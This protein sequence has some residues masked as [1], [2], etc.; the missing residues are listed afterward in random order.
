MAA[1]RSKSMA[2]KTL[3][4]RRGFRAKTSDMLNSKRLKGRSV[5]SLLKKPK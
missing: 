2:E 5:L 4:R 3:L 1:R